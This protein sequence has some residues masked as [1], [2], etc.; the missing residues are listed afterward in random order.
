VSSPVDTRNFTW[1]IEAGEREVLS[2]PMLQA[3]GVT[4]KD[5][6]GYSVD[7]KI[8]DEQGGEVLYTFPPEHITI[9]GSDIELLIPGPVSAAWVWSVGW[10]RMVITVPDPDPLDPETDRVV[11]GA[12]IVDAD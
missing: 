12:F 9:S 4:P 1:R 7:A 10:W 6:T 11:Q 5:V 8:R 3:D 2:V